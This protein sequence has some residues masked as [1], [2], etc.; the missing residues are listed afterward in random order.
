MIFLKLGGSLLSDSGKPFVMNWTSLGTVIDSLSQMD[1][2]MIV[3]HGGGGFGNFIAKEYAGTEVGF[4]KIRE[5]MAR[6]NNMVVSSFI[7]KG[8]PAVGF[9]PGSFMVARNGKITEGFFDHIAGAVKNY[10]P[11]LHSDAVL[12]RENGYSYVSAEK[13]MNEIARHTKPRRVLIA[14]SSPLL[15]DGEK[16]KEIADWNYRDIVSTFT[17]EIQAK[18]IET[19]ELSAGHRIEAYVFDG[20]SPDAIN[21]AWKYGEGTRIQVTRVPKLFD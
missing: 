6:M 15:M 18:V 13:I 17:P 7:A 14:C 1:E 16:V 19:A 3:F 21:R 12:D 2:E 20:S 10:V 11:V 8:I 9:S 4:F 5:A